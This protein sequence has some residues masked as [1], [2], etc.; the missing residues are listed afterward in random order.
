MVQGADRLGCFASG[1]HL[2]TARRIEPKYGAATVGT[3]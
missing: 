1:R 2:P 3:P